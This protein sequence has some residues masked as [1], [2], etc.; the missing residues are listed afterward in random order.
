MGTAVAG[1]ATVKSSVAK[2]GEVGELV[3]T[4]TGTGVGE[5]GGDVGAGKTVVGVR[6]WEDRG[7]AVRD[8]EGVT[9]GVGCGVMVM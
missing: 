1:V 8:G 9:K 4:I 2:G 3:T 7:A 6:L 5:S